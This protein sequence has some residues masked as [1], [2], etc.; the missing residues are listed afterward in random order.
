MESNTTTNEGSKMTKREE[1][2]DK[3]L[4]SGDRAVEAILLAR[5]E[6]YELGYDGEARKLANAARRVYRLIFGGK[7]K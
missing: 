5:A 7:E 6:V 2:W 1:E 3:V 4:N